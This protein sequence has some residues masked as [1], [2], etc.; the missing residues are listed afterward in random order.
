M[1]KHAGHVMADLLAGY[2]VDTVFGLPGGQTLP[3]YYGIMANSDKMKHI[4]MRDENNAV[5]AAD[6]YARISRKLGV[7]DGTAGCGPVKYL[8]GF[9]EAMN[10]SSPVLGIAAEMAYDELSTRY[11]GGG[12]QLVDAQGIVKPVTKWTGRL[13]RAG[14][15]AELTQFAARTALSGRPGPVY[16]ECPWD[17]FDDEYDGP[18]YEADEHLTSTPPYRQLPS[19]EELRKALELLKAAK[20]PVILAGG[21][22][23]FS[24]AKEELTKFAETM[25]IPVGTS[26][27][28]KGIV[29]ENGPYSI[30][31]VSSLGGSEFA[32]NTAME[33]DLIFAVGYK[34]SQMSTFNWTLPLKGQKVIHLDIDMIEIG[35]MSKVDIGL[36]GDVKATIARMLELE[37]NSEKK[38]IPESVAAAKEGYLRERAAS[39]RK[40]T[41]IIPQQV[42]SIINEICDENTILACDASFSCGWAAMY[43]DVYG[44]RRT[45]MPRGMSGLG[46]GLPAGIGAAAARPD[47]TVVV[48]TGDGGF[49]YC[50]GELQTIHEQ[51]MN[52][53]VIVLN[54]K[55]LGW[56]KWYQAGI[57]D[58]CFT[59][60]DTMRNDYAMIAKGS[61]IQGYNL[62]DPETL[63]EDLEKII[64]QPGP[65]LVDIIT[66]ETEACKFTD[67]E[68]A[69]K[70]VLDD[71]KN[72]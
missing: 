30:G 15:A 41:P 67:D 60:V 24:D 29:D 37:G 68:K 9:A 35:K 19:D 66:T 16:I 39:I 70:Y 40:E 12:A 26:L 55:T 59:E 2:G 61:G 49:N 48:L 20:N 23:W 51:N 46:Y 38:N 5:F 31:V 25:G 65:A 56:I 6:A 54:N 52:V 32:K 28:G 58:G 42:I 33:A 45:L 7:C 62:S 4:L 69:V 1:K 50:L 72:K 11:R 57:W 44:N 17:L 47:D 10:A 36:N 27:S 64:S 43:Y 3:L 8:S 21:G 18:E 14:K 53:K 34:F 22:A 63:R 13:P 71:H